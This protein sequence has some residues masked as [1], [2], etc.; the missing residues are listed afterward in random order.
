[1]KALVLIASGLQ[2][3]AVGCYGNDW[4]ETPTLDGLAA[5]GVVFDQH[6]ADQPDAA[7][8]RRAWRTGWYGLLPRDET[9]AAPPD[10]LALLRAAGVGTF[11]IRDGSRPDP[12][13]FADGWQHLR[14]VPPEGDDGTPLERTLEA[15]QQA[16]EDLAD[17]D[18]WLVCLEL[19]TL[20]PPWELPDGYR[21]RYCEPDEDDAEPVEPLTD[22]AGGPLDPKDDTTFIRLQ[23][24]YAAAVT[25]LDAGLGL[26]LDDL[27]ERDQLDDLVILVTTDRGQALGEHGVVGPC[28]AWPHEELIHLP[29]LLRL[30]G[31]A[32]AGRR[33]PHLTQAV[34]LMPTLLEA[35]GLSPAAVHGHSL[36]PLAHGRDEV[37]RAYACAGLRCGE[38]EGWA[39]RTPAW[40]FLL[41]VHSAADGP[42]R[43]PQLYVKPDDRCEVNDVRQHHL[44][45]VEHLEQTL[46]AFAEATR[47]PV[48]LEAPVLRDVEAESTATDGGAPPEEEA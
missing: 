5:E 34:D 38:E 16:L 22:P 21:D 45:L 9:P 47:R 29:L 36:W 18:D 1:M 35:F 17:R 26:L 11:L 13:E 20:L 10:L 42:P 33:V 27:R 8:A 12:P 19:G 2:L 23:R 15:A 37:V 48:P 39:L 25:Y 14:T 43:L 4:I 28:R 40:A 41:P 30:P 32:E 44:E 46:H 6:F 7:G 24:T 3:G 31:A